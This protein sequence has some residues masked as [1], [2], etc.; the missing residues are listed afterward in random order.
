MAALPLLLLEHDLPRPELLCA[1]LDGEVR[2]LGHGFCPVDV[3]ASVA[4][5]ALS[6]AA[7]VPSGL[8]LERRSAAWLWGVHPLFIDPVQLCLPAHRR[9]RP[10]PGVAVREV[11]LD[12]TDCVR[13]GAVVATGAFRTALDLL[14]WEPFFDR[15]AALAVTTLLL[16]DD[17]LR[18]RLEATLLAR[19]SLAHK[20]RALRRLRGL[21]G[22]TG[23]AES[24]DPPGQPPE[25]PGSASQP[26][27]TR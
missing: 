13:V 6:I 26:P 15:S 3:P 17:G 20:H 18:P 21:G 27:E 22:A 16:A 14:R 1:R 5:R 11:V 8:V 24:P 10:P 9:I 25:T 19:S 2:A 23:P 7:A 4:L 12:E